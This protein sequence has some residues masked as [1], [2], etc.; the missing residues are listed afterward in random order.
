[1]NSLLFTAIGFAFLGSLKGE[2]T[3]PRRIFEETFQIFS[4]VAVLAGAAL[5]LKSQFPLRKDEFAL[6]MIPAVYGVCA[7]ARRPLVFFFCICGLTFPFLDSGYSGGLLA[8][9]LGSAALFAGFRLI[10]LGFQERSLF[11]RPPAFFS[12][13]PLLLIQ[14]FWAS[15]LLTAWML[16]PYL[17]P[18]A[19]I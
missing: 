16:V 8:G 14:A 4:C 11:Y 15:L 9:I 3:T 1:M 10:V 5:L 13:M 6:G 2:K 18:S 12:G 17:V 19:G 7:L